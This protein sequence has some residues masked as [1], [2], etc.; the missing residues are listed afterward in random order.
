MVVLVTAIHALLRD[1]KTRMAESS[2]PWSE[3]RP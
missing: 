1:E 2:L 3:D